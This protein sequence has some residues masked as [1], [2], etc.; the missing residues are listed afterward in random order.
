MNLGFR[1]EKTVRF[2]M[3]CV[4]LL[5][6]TGRGAAVGNYVSHTQ[7]G[8]QIDFSTGGNQKV[9]IYVC[10]PGIV[11]VSLDDRGTFSSKRDVL[12]MEDVNRTWPEVSPLTVTDASESVVI[13][14]S[15]L[16]ITVQKSPFRI[17]Y[18]TADGTA[19][20]ADAAAMQSTG[21]SSGTPAFTFTQREDEHYFG[22]G[23]AFE[24]FRRGYHEIDNK[25][26][27]Y[28]TRRSTACYMYSTGGY[29][30]WF[31]FAEPYP[32]GSSWGD[33][34]NPT[35]GTGFDLRG[36]SAKYWMNP[37]TSPGNGGLMDY[38]SYFFILGD[39]WKEAMT[40]Y[41]LV[42]GRPP[43]LG[44]KFYGIMRDMYF[45]SGTTIDKFKGW[46]DMFRTNRFNMDWVR[47]D[48][49]FDWTNLGFLPSVRNSG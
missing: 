8:N 24:Q 18:A 19:L 32:N 31:L 34:S 38:A 33:I 35:N 39:T 5:A 48:N 29:G 14:T 44:K 2:G 10:T 26:Q 47:M 9:R 7:N 46:A 49:F 22:W 20:T 17:S 42:S 12:G 28:S 23:A 36:T 30:M 16:K 15:A 4:A 11:R 1:I 37:S 25:N 13:A 43:R 41:T 45:R 40:G 21:S 6:G 3:I 27:T